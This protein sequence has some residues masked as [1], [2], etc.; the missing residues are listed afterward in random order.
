MTFFKE[1]DLDIKLVKIVK[2]QGLC[3]LVVEDQDL[4]NSED[5]GW[6]NE[7]SLW[8]REYLCVLPR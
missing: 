2:G 5:S 4:I 6:E 7:L 1:F 8:C 3:K